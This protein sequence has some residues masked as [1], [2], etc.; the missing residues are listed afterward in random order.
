M[1]K[2]RPGRSAAKPPSQPSGDVHVNMESADAY[3]FCDKFPA[4]FSRATDDDA[5]AKAALILAV[6][7]QERKGIL[8]EKALGTFWGAAGRFQRGEF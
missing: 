4:L 3:T 8:S 6:T 7:P 1:E 2:R 5:C